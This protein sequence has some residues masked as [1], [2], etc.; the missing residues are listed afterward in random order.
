MPEL[1]E[2]E[3]TRLGIQPHLAGRSLLGATVREPRLRWPVP[4][5][6]DQRL[7]GCTIAD[8]DRRA[9]YI[10]LRLAP[11][12]GVLIHLGM[13]GSLRVVPGGEAPLRH[14]HVD[15]AL[16][17]DRV[18]RFH[19]PRRFG[20]M[21]ATD[22]DPADHPRLH[23]LGPEPLE[24]DFTGAHLYSRTRTRKGAGRTTPVK[25]FLLDAG[26]VVGVGNIYAN[27]ALFRAGIRPDR[28]AGDL[29]EE[30]CERL[31]GTL[32]AVLE[33]AIAA[34]GTTLRDFA[35]SDG[36]PGY[37]RQALAVYGRTGEACP[38]CGQALAQMAVA[39][40]S[41]FYCPACQT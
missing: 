15:L 22:D 5:D 21:L 37:F 7:A 17:N 39:Q 34:G 13:S 24:P 27:E 28:R 38:A 4:A 35:R 1:P 11:A 9:K 14:D 36:S 30:G 20:A 10:L 40:R 33:E 12:G 3:V 31:A 2:V 29:G 41:A 18:L 8:V 6:L 19:D 32:A 26:V 16:D 23:G 25:A